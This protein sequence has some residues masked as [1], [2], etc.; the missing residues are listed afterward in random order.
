MGRHSA[1]DDTPDD[2][3]A[4]DAEGALAVATASVSELGTVA[5]FRR[6]RHARD[7]EDELPAVDD[8][9]RIAPMRSVAGT[10]NAE[11]QADAEL[12]ADADPHTDADAKAA[13]APPAPAAAPSSGSAADLRLVRVHAD[14]RARC[15]AAVVVPFAAYVVVFAVLG[16]LGVSALLWM[17][18]PLVT[19]G[20]LV[21]V[22]LDAGHKR[23]GDDAQ[24]P[25][26]EV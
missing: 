14:V 23:Y 17:W 18:I 22:F 24:A 26:P 16:R 9:A 12:Q 1:L 11:P 21:G 7:D 2:A 5:T 13:A 20:V 4:A 10:T 3:F 8:T 15:I 25:A 6:G 19:S